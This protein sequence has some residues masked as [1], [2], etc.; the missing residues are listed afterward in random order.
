MMMYD[1]LIESG[2]Y[3]VLG[4]STFAAGGVTARAL[5]LQE[6]L[7][8]LLVLLYGL[9]TINQTQSSSPQTGH[10]MSL[11]R[12][13]SIFLLALWGLFLVIGIQ[14]L[15]LPR[16]IV[17]FF[18]PMSARIYSEA[19]ATTQTPI[20]SWL[21]LTLSRQATLT[22]YCELLSYI[23]IFFLCLQ[24]FQK[25]AR[26]LRL[27]TALVAIGFVE[28]LY[29]LLDFVSNATPTSFSWANGSFV[30]KNH[31]AGYLELIIPLAFASLLV[32]FEKR[33]AGGAQTVEE[34]YMKSAFVLF[35]VFLMI[36]ALILSGSRGGLISFSIGILGFT[37]LA[38]MRGLMKRW[39]AIMLLIL[40]LAL[41]TFMIVNPNIVQK[42]T[43]RFVEMERSAQIR[44]EIWKSAWHIFQDFPV[45]GSGLGTYRHLSRRYKTFQGALAFEY[46]HNDYAQL[47]AET[48]LLGS[49]FVVGLGGSLI[50]RIVRTWRHQESRQVLTIATGGL[51]ALLSIGLHSVVDFNLHIPSNMMVFCVVAALTYNAAH[52]RRHKPSGKGMPST[53]TDKV[54]KPN[55]H[56]RHSQPQYLTFFL[57]ASRVSPQRRKDAKENGTRERPFSAPSR[58]CGEKTSGTEHSQHKMFTRR[59]YARTSIIL[60]GLI[61]YLFYVFT[62]FRAVTR[63]ESGK[64]RIPTDFATLDA[65]RHKQIL[66]DLRQA[67]RDASYQAAYAHALGKYI[68]EVATSTDPL[69]DPPLTT[70]GLAEAEEWITQAVLLDPANPHYYYTLG[71]LHYSQGDCHSWQTY[72][73]GESWDV[74]PVTVYF[75][76]ALRNAPTHPFYR[77][78]FG[79]W[80]AFYDVEQARQ[81]VGEFLSRDD[82]TAPVDHGVDKLARFLYEMH[83]DS[84]SDRVASQVWQESTSEP[85][86]GCQTNILDGGADSAGFEVGTDDGT[87]EWSTRLTDEAQRI[88]KRLCLPADIDAF[89]QASLLVYANRGRERDFVI[90]VGIDGETKEI[91]GDT[92]GMIPAWHDI[93]IDMDWIAG[94]SL[95]QV[96]LRIRGVDSTEEA[97]VIWGDA[98]TPGDNSEYNFRGKKDLSTESGK[99]TGEYMIRLRLHTPETPSS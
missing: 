25:P 85:G 41:G 42:H 26:L 91:S 22:E 94:K 7:V 14:A 28:A 60:S 62:S 57:A 59:R 37:F 12:F 39:L 35:T 67:V 92:F 69:S 88:K 75:R 68:Y 96:Y 89:T 72:H 32:H 80:Y 95:V 84:E 53:S 56:T 46:S 4:I 3:V 23:A 58:L 40:A 87:A 73:P 16:G 44:N 98:D 52:I 8:A 43:S 47:L 79:R 30:N 49:F 97:L 77:E 65:T 82:P 13:P 74:C 55:T 38:V 5:A 48:G 1:T 27:V 81:H 29:G 24:T 11:L 2:L 70:G 99:Q 93:P 71:Q 33:A 54:Q 21:P 76:T 66:A 50:F 78:A 9:K 36:C 34:K 64:H 18:S 10:R 19:A 63:Y 61:F 15:P 51:C 86:N 20:Q 45:F 83:M 90:T 6:M 17:E 31:F